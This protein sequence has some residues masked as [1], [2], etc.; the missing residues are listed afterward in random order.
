MQKKNAVGE[1]GSRTPDLIQAINAKDPS[2]LDEFSSDVLINVG[3]CHTVRPL[4][5][6]LT[7]QCVIII[8]I[9]CIAANPSQVQ[10]TPDFVKDGSFCEHD[11][12]FPKSF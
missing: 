3:W 6:Q 10:A 7:I 8:Y 11:N 12:T 5:P 2:Y 9:V 4:P 1:A